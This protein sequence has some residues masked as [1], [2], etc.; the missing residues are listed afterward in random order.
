M[1]RTRLRPPDAPKL[2]TTYR[3]WQDFTDRV[4][5][6]WLDDDGEDP[7]VDNWYRTLMIEA[8]PWYLACALVLALDNIRRLERQG[9]EASGEP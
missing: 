5:R 2:G 3:D 1:R 8:D 9:E 6:P 7:R 4:A